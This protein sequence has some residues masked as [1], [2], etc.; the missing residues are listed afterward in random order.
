VAQGNYIGIDASGSAAL[1]NDFVGVRLTGGAHGNTIGG[2]VAGSRNVV[3]ANG[4]H[5]IRLHS[6]PQGAA[7][8]NLVQGN[9]IGTDAAGATDLGNAGDGVAVS[10]GATNNTIGG[11]A[12][13]ARNTISGNDSH[14]VEIVDETT[15][16]NLV[17]GNHIGT[18]RTGSAGLGNSEDGVSINAPSNTIGGTTA[19]A[20]N[21]ISANTHNGVEINIRSGNLVQGNFIGTDAAGAAPLGNLGHG[22]YVST[23]GN[24]VGGS[25]GS[26]GTN[27]IAF[28][29]GD[30]MRISSGSGNVLFLNSV[31]SNSGL[32]I[33]LGHDG[34][35]ANDA[36]DGDVG[37]NDLQ[38]YPNLTW[39]FA[40]GGTTIQGA[41]NST[42]NTSF[43]LWFYANAT[44][45]PS[46]HGEGRTL[47]GAAYVTTDGSGDATF[48]TTVPATMALGE[49]VTALATG[50]GNNTSE[51]SA[52]RA[53]AS[54]PAPTATLAP[55]ATNTPTS[56]PPTATSTPVASTATPAG[57][58]TPGPSATATPMWTATPPAASAGD[59]NCDG[60]VNSIDAALVLQFAAGLIGSLPCAQN[61]DVN[62]DGNVDAIDATL[63]LQYDAGL[64]DSL[65]P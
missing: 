25:F 27:T 51:Y 13:G 39:A 32:G 61:A 56:A 7:T 17:Q 19:G 45:D 18:N 30:G 60:T 53:V 23:S 35:T 11:T 54:G 34:V 49:F 52:C 38:N 8:N 15:T 50:P 40:D 26:G 46:G 5:G 37:A 57:P 6:N 21:V 48:D 59:V 12:S 62:G 16:G 42:P 4:S 65:P 64:I 1:G 58:P 36:G 20:G 2:T 63:I 28:N 55:T 14:G 22:L 24:V 41:F 43:A 9:L 47:I 31:F 10:D 33:D 29:G 3:S 44:C